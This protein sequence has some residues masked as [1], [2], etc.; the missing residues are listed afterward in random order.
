MATTTTNFGW[1]IPQSTDLVKDGATA[2]AALGQDIDTAF[3]DLKGGTTGQ[4]LAKASNTDLDYT[5]TTPEIGDITAVTAGTG[6]SGG[7]TSGAVTIT[8]SMATA[9]DAKGDLIAGTGADTFSRIA[10]GANG[11]QLYADSSA[12]TGLRWQGSDEAGKNFLING[13]FDIWQRGTSFSVAAFNFPYTADRW[14]TFNGTP[15]TITQETSTVPTGANYAL[16][17]TGGATTAGYEIYQSIESVNAI[18]LAG[19]QITASVQATGTTGKTHSITVEYSTAVDPGAA[20][21]SWTG[22]SPAASASVTSGTFSPIVTSV[23]IPSNAKSIRLKIT[24]GSL[25][26]GEFAI[27]GNA[28]IEQGYVATNFSRAGATIGGELALCQRYYYLHASGTSKMVGN[29]AY[30]SGAEVDSMIQF[31]VTMRTA[32]TIDQTTG[33]DYYT[34]YRN[35]GSDGFNSFTVSYASTTGTNLFNASQ[36]SGTAGQA[37]QIATNNASAYLGFSAEL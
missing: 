19:K 3:V 18:R 29:G 25:T 36:V 4:V 37:G 5:W 35:G 11:E 12:S 10:A 14:T 16:K 2:I 15:M 34:F 32:P 31:P 28:Q 13:G 23:A 27:F 8:N 6:I 9:I 22:I 30:Y 24:I 26:S 20:L 21:G 17:L 33:T 1:D 7:G